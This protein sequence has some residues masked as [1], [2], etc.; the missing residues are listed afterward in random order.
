MPELTFNETVVEIA[1]GLFYARGVHDVG[2]D[3][4]SVAAKTSL[5]RLYKAFA[6]KDA[7]VIAVIT[8][9]HERWSAAI[10]STT[11]RA[12]DPRG[13][14]LAVYDFLAE[15]FASDGF[16][17]CGFINTFGELGG[18][19]P[20]IAALTRNHKQSF[21]EH[22]SRLVAEAGAPLHLAPQLSILAEGAQTTAAISGNADA[23]GQARAAAEVLIDAA[24]SNKGGLA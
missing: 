6:S 23:A 1:Q 13:R 14:L 22:M 4:I 9:W 18:I 20:E 15:W 2:M 8:G 10:D 21:Q 19:S 11:A 3:E 7:I 16:R 12:V 5:K 17:G 24:L